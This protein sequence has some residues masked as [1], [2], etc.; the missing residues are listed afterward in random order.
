MSPGCGPSVQFCPAH[1]NPFYLIGTATGQPAEAQVADLDVLP[2]R[3]R[4]LTT[5]PGHILILASHAVK[6]N[7]GRV[8]HLLPGPH[9]G[10]GDA[11]GGA[12]AALVA[13]RSEGGENCNSQTMFRIEWH[14]WDLF[15]LSRSSGRWAAH[16]GSNSP[17][18]HSI[19]SSSS[20]CGDCARVDGGSVRARSLFHEQARALLGVW[21]RRTTWP[22]VFEA[23]S[24]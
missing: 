20:G 15:L 22:P 17:S 8:H 21:K 1:V 12:I 9:F 3:V 23:A 13:H 4:L 5:L 16:K 7:Q 2:T 19:L 24:R 18:I 11:W 14:S 10:G 6:L